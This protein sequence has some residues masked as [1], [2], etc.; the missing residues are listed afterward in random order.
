MQ[1]FDPRP[2]G[3]DWYEDHAQHVLSRGML[4]TYRALAAPPMSAARE[5]AIFGREG[6]QECHHFIS[7]IFFQA[8]ENGDW[9]GSRPRLVNDPY[10]RVVT[11]PMLHRDPGHDETAWRNV[12]QS[13]LGEFM[14]KLHAGAVLL[15]LDRWERLEEEDEI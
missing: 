8:G 3:A 4:R 6:P 12:S 7:E 11:L 1:P 15:D 9:Y 14:S 5:R 2:Q 13:S 10:S